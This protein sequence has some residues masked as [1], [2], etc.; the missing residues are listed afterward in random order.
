MNTNQTT[1]EQLNEIAGLI[2][3]ARQN[4][5]PI[6]PISETFGVQ[7]S[8]AAYATAGQVVSL[9]VVETQPSL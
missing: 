6:A 9:G 7:D 5:A 4:G 1:D 8:Q 3:D 2:Y